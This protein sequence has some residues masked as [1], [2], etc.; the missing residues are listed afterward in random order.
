MMRST[1]VYRFAPLCVFAGALALTGCL[2]SYDSSGSSATDGGGGSTDG[3]SDAPTT[4]ETEAPST[5]DPTDGG[6]G[7]ESTGGDA[8]PTG[9]CGAP[10]YTWLPADG[11]GE[12]LAQQPLAE[13]SAA[14]IDGL[15]EQNGFGQFAPVS[16]GAQI[17]KIRYRT[18][19][20]GKAIET[21]GFTAFPIG[22][23]PES[24][25]VVVWAHGTSGFTDKCA[26]TAD[27]LGFQIPLILAAKGFVA[28]APDYIGMNG[29]GAP[30]GQIHPYIVPEPTA[31]AVLDSARALY[32]FVAK[33]PDVP[34]T[35]TDQIVLFGA[36]EGGFATLWADRYAPHYAPELKFVANVAAVPPTDAYGLTEHGMTVFGP[37]TGALAAAIVG[38]W[39]W[40]GR[41]APLSEV[42]SS[43]PPL[44]VATELPKMMQS[45]CSF[46]LPNE[47][48]ETNQV[49]NQAFID[50]VVAQDWDAA[51]VW[52]CLLKQASLGDSE[53]PLLTHTPT[54]I[55]QGS[56]DDLVYTP[57]VREDLPRLCDQGY[58]IEHIECAGAGHVDAVVQ[59]VPYSIAWVEDR[60]AGKPL[61]D[62]CTIHAPVDC[63]EL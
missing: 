51:G 50:A 17:F 9:G 45:D 39:D 58:Q 49:Y 35:P 11:M 53:I 3:T 52:G 60:L 22:E 43:G 26:P 47:I 62:P 61:T 57:V 31:I 14:Q 33:N 4:G 40:L 59:T 37:T 41:T 36:S 21:T 18:Q 54:L 44:D 19:D 24:R 7:G 28:V 42:L 29:W 1:M 27:P 16:Y 23:G 12:I 63:T 46:D 5:G 34:T 10:P 55:A 56:A 15:L 6:S 32:D 38:G 2:E 30:S 25:P 8:V 20:R 13:F 48:T